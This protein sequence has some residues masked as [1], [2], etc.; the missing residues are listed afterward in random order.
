MERQNLIQRLVA[1][2]LQGTAKDK[3]LCYSPANRKALCFASANVKA[4]CWTAAQ[5]KN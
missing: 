5:P 1:R 4:L 2:K 3:A